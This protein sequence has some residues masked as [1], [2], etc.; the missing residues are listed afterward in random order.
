MLFFIQWSSLC[1]GCKV[2]AFLWSHRFTLL[3]CVSLKPEIK[4]SPKFDLKLKLKESVVKYGQNIFFMRVFS[5]GGITH[6]LVRNFRCTF[7]ALWP[8]EG[9]VDPG[10]PLGGAR[11]VHKGFFFKDRLL[12]TALCPQRSTKM[13][14]RNQTKC[15][16][17]LEPWRFSH[18]P[19]A[20]TLNGKSSIMFFPCFQKHC[21]SS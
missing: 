8:F 12:S 1:R 7:G 10:G 14:H 9:M 15:A 5:G 4:L 21:Q 6:R 18:C 11:A 20:P 19:H 17:V 16:N 3:F 2:A 13:R